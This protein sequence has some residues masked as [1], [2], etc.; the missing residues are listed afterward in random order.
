MCAGPRRPVFSGRL[1]AALLGV[2]LACALA[3]CRKAAAPVAD[4]LT[5]VLSNDVSSLDPN[6]E[7]ESVTDSV[8][9]NAY[10]PLVAFDHDLRAQ[11]LIA[12]SWQ[13]LAPE[14][15]RFKLRANVRFHDGALL[16]ADDVRESLL[17]LRDAPTLEAAH[18]GAVIADV[19][20][21]APD[22]VE[23]VTREPRSLLTSLPFLYITRPAPAGTFPPFIGT[24]PYRIVERVPGH[25]VRLER[26]DT[27]WGGPAAYRE[28]TFVPVREPDQ[29]ALRITQGLADIAYGIPHEQLLKPLPGVR[30]VRHAGLTVYYIGLDVGDRPDNPFRDQRV[31]EAM[32]LAI[33]REALVRD[34]LHGAGAPAA[35]PVAPLVFGYEPAIKVPARDVARAKSLMAAAGFGSGFDVRIDL[36]R[37]RGTLGTLL[38][39]QLAEVGIRLEPHNVEDVYALAES[40]KSAMFVVGWD[41][42]SGE[43]SE[44]YEFVLHTRTKAFGQGNYGGWSNAEID[45]IAER[46]GAEL[47]TRKRQT[48][49][50]EA[51]TLSMRELPVIPLYVADDVY[52]V[53]EGI[54]LKLRADSE[55]RLVDLRPD[56]P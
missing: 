37:N 31:R 28:V 48:M 25:K 8:L 34:S 40:G 33:D 56:K 24:G 20:A 44:F 9:F 7:V 12:E 5:I 3:A 49:L 11:P 2:L 30:L 15:W 14:R 38:R 1:R 46:N 55:I 39:A 47:D 43:S 41:C 17:R 52:A 26:V 19:V 10:E 54:S 27:Y 23:V 13:H 22:T 6:Q 18:F 29:R 53:R 35:Q 45:R 42:S 21:V 16:T 50:R 32:H 4:T 51:A 36:P